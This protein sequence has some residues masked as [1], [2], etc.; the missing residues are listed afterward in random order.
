MDRTN[1][2]LLAILRLDIEGLAGQLTQFLLSVSNA[3]LKKKI[4]NFLSGIGRV[5]GMAVGEK[6]KK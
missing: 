2:C 3:I 5:G 1:L 4:V 6:N